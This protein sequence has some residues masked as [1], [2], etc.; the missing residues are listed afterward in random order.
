[1]DLILGT[2]VGYAPGRVRPFLESLRRHY[3]SHAVVVTAH[4][5]ADTVEMLRRFRVTQVAVDVPLRTV[6]I[7]RLRHFAY[8]QIVR[9]NTAVDRI[10]LT[11][12]GDVL[13]QGDPFPM[14][15]DGR[16]A[17]FLEDSAIGTCRHNSAW[18]RD[19][20]GPARLDELAG[21][22]ISCAGTVAGDRE[23]VL[24]YL[25]L[26]CRDIRND[27]GSKPSFDQAH[28]NHLVYGELADIAIHVENRTG[29]VQTLHHQQRFEFDRL[30]RLI[31]IDG[32]VCP[33]VHQFNRHPVFFP[34]FG[35]NPAEYQS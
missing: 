29:A 26:M 27:R 30:G 8:Q 13:F 5:P 34:L 11:D 4:L 25:D 10:L 12:V 31:N 14:L 6:M 20:Y 21:R 3:A 35:I 23:S 2:C 22:P 17:S 32:R 18:I 7:Q 9:G 24:R 33:V 19:A 28:H 16:L 1:M 15:P